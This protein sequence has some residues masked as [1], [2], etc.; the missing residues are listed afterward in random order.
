[1]SRRL[2]I[3]VTCGADEPERLS[4]ALTVAATAV[5]SGVE[6]SLWLTGDASWL[7]VPGRV[8][9]LGLEHALSLGDL[10]ETVLAGGRMTLCSQCAAR[11]EITPESVWDGVR[12]AGAATF[13][14]EATSSD[15]QALIY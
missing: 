5:A 10:V 15:V 11:R 8:P 6:V 4:Q 12:I 14:D 7:A 2:L 1:M 9:D 13:V 3:K